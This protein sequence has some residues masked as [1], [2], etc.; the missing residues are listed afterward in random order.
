MVVIILEYDFTVVYKLGRTHVIIDALSKLLNNIEPI[1]VL[2]QTTNANLFYTRPKWL[3]D[4][5]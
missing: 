4:V 1:G 3:N 5:K 2:N